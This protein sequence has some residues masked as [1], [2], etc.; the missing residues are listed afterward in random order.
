[1]KICYN[2]SLWIA[3]ILVLATSCAIASTIT[4][5]PGGPEDIGS[6]PTVLTH[7]Y[8]PGGIGGMGLILGQPNTL[9]RNDRVLVRF[10]ISKILL[11]PKAASKLMRAQLKFKMDGS[12][13]RD[14][15]STVEVTH[16]AH[17]TA[18]GLVGTDMVREPAPVV[19]K[20]KVNE[21]KTAE[22]TL[23]VTKAVFSD[24]AKGRKFTSY[25][26][27]DLTAEEKGNTFL[28]AWFVRLVGDASDMPT[29]ELTFWDGRKA[30]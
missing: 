5:K 9:T 13:I 8:S 15:P 29:L 23:D 22:Y 20:L 14:V 24:L 6:G 2:R 28:S 17:D 18:G 26:W 3:A 12:Y 10:D 27:R 1:M 11:Q 30:K 4:L 25:R 16:L 7:L 19:G 21:P